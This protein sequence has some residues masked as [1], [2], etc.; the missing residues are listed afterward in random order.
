MTEPLTATAIMQARSRIN[1]DRAMHWLLHH[2]KPFMRAM[3]HKY[4]DEMPD[5]SMEWHA[6]IDTSP[7]SVILEALKRHPELIFA[8]LPDD[9]CIMPRKGLEKLTGLSSELIEHLADN[10]KHIVQAHAAMERERMER[11]NG[12]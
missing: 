5:H 7:G 11:W 1:Y 2:L 10:G 9:V 4:E 6:G 12:K 8:A 3:P